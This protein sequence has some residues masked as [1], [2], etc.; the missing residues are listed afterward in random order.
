M[1]LK[2]VTSLAIIASMTVLQASALTAR[3]D[4][5]SA[6]AKIPAPAAKPTLPVDQSADVD[7]NDKWGWGWGWGRGYYGGWG[8]YYPWYGRRYY[9]PYWY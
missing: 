5:I 4:T 3:D 6:Q 2:T 1:M 8:G 7:E 9:R